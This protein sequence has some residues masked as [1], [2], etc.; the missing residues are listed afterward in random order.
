MTKIANATFSLPPNFSIL[1]AVAQGLIPRNVQVT[2]INGAPVP[3]G[4]PNPTVAQLIAAGV[5]DGS[6]PASAL[7]FAGGPQFGGD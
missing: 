2:S 5:L 4:L 1:A 6:L 7:G 3:K